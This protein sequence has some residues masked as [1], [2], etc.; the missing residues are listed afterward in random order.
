MRAIVEKWGSSAAVRIASA[1]MEQARLEIGQTVELRV[2]GGRV[3]I[4]PLTAPECSLDDLLAGVTPE[5]LHDEESF[6]PPAVR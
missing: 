3:V 5:N 6:G 1:V 2:E 4:E